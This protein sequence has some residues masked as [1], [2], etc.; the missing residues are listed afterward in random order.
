MTGQTPKVL[1]IDDDEIIHRLVG[2][3]LKKGG[4]L[5]LDAY[6]GED[7]LEMA[8]TQNPQLIILD[9]MMPG[10]NG[11]EVLQYL[12]ASPVTSSIPVIFLT[13]QVHQSDKSQA[14]NLGAVD[15][16]EKP[17]EHKELLARIDTYVKTKTHD[18]DLSY[19]NRRLTR[20]TQQA[21]D[22]INPKNEVDLEDL[23]D[24]SVS[25]LL[26]ELE[27]AQDQLTTLD[28]KWSFLADNL[29]PDESLDFPESIAQLRSHLTEIQNLAGRLAASLGWSAA[30][31]LNC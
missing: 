10:L 8:R 3:V 6:R 29:K 20:V 11:F 31:D 21:L 30:R 24:A 5:C 17:F 16:M 22:L 18:R 13:G 14:K 9:I 1:V 19:L 26:S 28:V 23:P 2:A 15:F 12:K 7:G 27:A 25:R 4:Y